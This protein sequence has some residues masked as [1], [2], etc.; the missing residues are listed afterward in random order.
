MQ[1]NILDLTLNANTSL[2]PA[3]ICVF[4]NLMWRHIVYRLGPNQKYYT[5]ALILLIR[6]VMLSKTY[7]TKCINYKNSHMKSH[8][9]N[10]S[11]SIAKPEASSQF[12]NPESQIVN[13][14]IRQ[15][16]RRRAGRTRKTSSNP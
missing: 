3:P 6:I 1:E 12:P 13:R 16:P 5:F 14:R 4:G 10:P 2:N 15:F 8:S 11:G 9:V 7:W